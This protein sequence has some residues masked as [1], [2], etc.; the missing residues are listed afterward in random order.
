MELTRRWIRPLLL[1][2]TVLLAIP[3]TTVT[4]A[5]AAG[6]TAALQHS[7]VGAVH[8]APR[9]N[10]EL[11]RISGQA[12]YCYSSNFCYDVGGGWYTEVCNT[13]GVGEYDFP[14]NP[15]DFTFNQSCGTRVWLHEWANWEVNG[16]PNGWAY[17][18][19]PGAG[20]AALP[21]Q[22][23]DPFNIYVSLNTSAC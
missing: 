5:A 7:T 15:I 4:V 10:P 6:G 13:P 16:Q 3:A 8:H 21:S 14:A 17:C 23:A 22:Y 1:A 11:L 20:F 2:L 18:I 19:S 9:R 12:P